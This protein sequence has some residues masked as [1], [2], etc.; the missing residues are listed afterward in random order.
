[1]ANIYTRDIELLSESLR[2]LANKH[3]AMVFAAAAERLIPLYEA[4]ASEFGWGNP[5]E[6]RGCLTAAWNSGSGSAAVAALPAGALG[7]VAEAIP[8]ADD[9][10]N[11]KVTLAQDACICLDAALKFLVDDRTKRTSWIEY[12]LEAVKTAVCWDLTGYLDVGD[13]LDDAAFYVQLGEDP[14]YQREVARIKRDIDVVT[15]STMTERARVD[16]VRRRAEED[17][18][19]YEALGI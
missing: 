16:L 14:R 18:W 11:L 6:L 5:V 10:D 8:D 15:L 2:P 12:N 3:V 19:S 17:A 4:F 13:S 7:I 1:M 9:F